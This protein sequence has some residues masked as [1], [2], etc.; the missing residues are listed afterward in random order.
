MIDFR[1][2]VV[3]LIS[4]FLALAVGIALGAGPLKE[5]IGDTLTGQVEQ[6]RG[7]KD[8]L[9]TQLDSTDADL[10]RSTTYIDAAAARMLP[11]SLAQRRVAVVALGG[12]PDKQR[13]AIEDR[14][15]Q[16]NATISADVTLTSAWTD[17]AQRAYRQAITSRMLPH[18][19]HQPDAGATADQQISA[20]LV[21]GLVDGDGADPNKLSADAQSLLDVLS[22]KEAGTPLI[23]VKNDVKAPADAV[24]VVAVPA[25]GTSGATASPAATPEVTASHVAVVSAAQKYSAGAVLADGPR[26]SGS[27]TDAVLSDDTLAASISTVSATGEVPGQVSVPLALAARIAD[28]VG[29]FGFGVGEKPLPPTVALPAVDRTPRPQGPP[30]ALS[31]PTATAGSH[32]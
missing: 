8:N 29:H 14:L 27:L 20:A 10:D 24:V 22:S 18:M 7:E 19:A 6:L 32:A 21:Q 12:V 25:A 5:T 17:Q 11:G 2:H 23:S 4:V 9:R 3:S 28:T 1:Y 13:K 30:T 26:G 31:T 15:T 16:A